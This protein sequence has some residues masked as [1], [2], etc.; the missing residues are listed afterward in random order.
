MPKLYLIP[1]SLTDS[2]NDDFLTVRNQEIIRSLKY[3]MIESPKP[4]HRLL[5]SAGVPTPFQDIFFQELSEHTPDTELN[6]IIKP[7][8]EGYSM[9]LITDAGYPAL[10]DP[11]EKVVKLAHNLKIQVVPL[12]GASSIML[13][14]AASGLNAE[15]FTFHGYLPVK[16]N[17]RIQKIR[18]LCSDMGRN[19]YTQIFIETPY[20][21]QA[22]FDDIAAHAGEDLFLCIAC[23]L[24]SDSEMILTKSIREWRKIRPDIHK[25]QVVFLLGN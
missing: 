17:E 24:S 20:R 11:G 4:A 25:R 18:M 22:L 6:E 10:A 2:A 9:G 16:K 8:A 19:G 5:K 7:L 15:Q 14:L 3:F 12:I 1:N 23:D 21:N 13:A